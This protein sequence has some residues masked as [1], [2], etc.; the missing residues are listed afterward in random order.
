MSKVAEGPLRPSAGN[1]R[2]GG[3]VMEPRP[4]TSSAAAGRRA[5]TRLDRGPRPEPA[6][7]GPHC[8]GPR[9]PQRLRRLEHDGPSSPSAAT[10]APSGVAV[11]RPRGG[12]GL[13]VG[14]ARHGLAGADAGGRA[15]LRRGA[16]RREDPQ[17]RALHRGPPPGTSGPASS[18]A[19][20]PRRSRAS[21]GTPPPT[22]DW[23]KRPRPCRPRSG[24]RRGLTTLYGTYVDAAI[25]PA[26]R[27][28][29][30]DHA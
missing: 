11:D 20:A 24:G 10:T 23:P 26:R 21:I 5:R 3:I 14:R 8:A 28:R 27:G 17:S 9:R 25:S 29:R 12:A 2:E 15:P 30:Q 7:P 18:T 4:A 6:G 19:G 13:E 1:R 16:Q 22:V